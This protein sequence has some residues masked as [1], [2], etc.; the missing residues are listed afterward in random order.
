MKVNSAN[1]SAV[2]GTEVS[3][4]GQAS[5][6]AKTE[7]AKASD[8]SRQV[9]QAPLTPEQSNRAEISPRAKEMA[10]AKSIA[11][12]TPDVREDKIAALKKKIAEGSYKVDANAVA[13]K[14]VS[15]HMQTA[16]AMA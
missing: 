5:K 1:A 14:M 13:E 16:A 6:A 7:K 10:Q 3:K 8:S 12:S 15:E 2:Q 4:S 11:Q 9:S